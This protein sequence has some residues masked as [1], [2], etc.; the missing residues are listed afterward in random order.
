M[1]QWLK[2]AAF[3]YVLLGCGIF[4]YAQEPGGN[5]QRRT[6]VTG[7][8]IDKDN[9]QPL[10]F[11][12]LVLQSVEDP[13]NV[14]GGIT[15]TEG[16]FEVQA[17]A[18]RYNIR[19]EFISYK[20]YEVK[21]RML[22][23][24]ND[25][26]TIAL[27]LDVSTLEA[28]E[29]TGERT[30]VEIK[31][32]KKVY[33]VGK[34][35]TNAGATISD[36]LNN[37]PSVAVDVEGGISLRGNQNVRILING[38]P[39]ALAGFGSTDAL[40]QLPA[41]AIE[42]IEVI[43][44]PSARY[45][46][47]GTAG[48]LNIVLKR[49]KTLGFNGTVQLNGGYPERFQATSNLNYR[50]KKFNF[51]NTIGY[52]Y[53]NSPGR[54]L[55]DN[56]YNPGSSNFERITEDRD[57]DRTSKGFN[58]NIGTEYFITEQ[59]S[60]TASFFT[61]LSDGVDLT[62]NI[63]DRFYADGTFDQSVSTEEENEEDRS[64]QTSLNF[65]HN[66]DEDGHNLTVDLQYS[67]DKEDVNTPIEER[68]FA[69]RDSLIR[70]DDVF[71]IQEQNDYLVQADYVL[72]IG[73]NARFEAGYRGSF[74]NSETDYLLQGLQLDPTLPDFGEVVV[75][76]GLTNTFNFEQ[77]INAFYTQYG[78]KFGKFSFLAGLR[79][80][81]TQLIGSVDFNEN[82]VAFPFDPNFDKNFLG[83]FPTANLTWE[84]EE[85]ENITLGY[86]R[87]INRPRSWQINPFPS[88]SS[89]TNIFQGNP[90]LNPAYANTFD[91]GYLKRWDKLTLTTSVYYQRETDSFEWITEETGEVT[92]DNIPI[93]RRTPINLSSEQRY[94]G[95][96]AVLW[97]P[98]KWMRINTSANVFR[99][100][101][102][103]EYNGTDFGASNLSWFARM[104][105]KVTLP[106]KIDW[107]TNAFYRGP[108]ENAQ[109]RT[110]GV[111]TLNLAFAKDIFNDNATISFNVNDLFNSGVRRSVSETPRVTSTSETQWRVR[112]FQVGFVYRFNQTKRQQQRGRGNDYGDD[113]EGGF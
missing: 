39:S 89:R 43:T 55:N 102:D 83:L 21:D 77:N 5:A 31:L 20:T 11:A 33:N 12:T 58:L 18:G 61:R 90:S 106:G 48:I 63:N 52:R 32:D 8:V 93:L 82:E 67:V 28:V 98:S 111:F 57:W 27:N 104:N 95:E 7:K 56:V 13:N 68:I 65:R 110:E 2:V 66:F 81:N 94:G 37:V 97:N 74:E 22:R 88:Q 107:Q 78:N 41:D 109:S 92:S 10:E 40:Q 17:P 30:T 105:A 86:N 62:T 47:E 60:V 14:T 50:T 3:L 59:T 79:L 64:Y 46:A 26:G 45:D 96:A 16:K 108:S 71:E 54:A 38:R 53:R 112:Q 72:P 91:L 49:D 42:K 29:V 4:S 15:D 35:L 70:D 44:S 24:R 34:D 103:G 75:N 113:D 36:A 84:F 73:E 25:L 1:R 99:F 51:F 85:N 87:R 19:V 6:T 80:E 23:G 100:V 76:F 101:K 9:G 69:P